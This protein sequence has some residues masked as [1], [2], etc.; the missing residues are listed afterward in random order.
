MDTDL[1]AIYRCGACNYKVPGE[2]A[3]RVGDTCACPK[4]GAEI[5]R[6]AS[7]ED[8]SSFEFVAHTATDHFTFQGDED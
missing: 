5:V 1:S 4:C 6:F 7:Y 8:G 2:M 3:A